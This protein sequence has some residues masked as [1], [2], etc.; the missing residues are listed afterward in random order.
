M[1]MDA[2]RFQHLAEAYGAD[3]RRWPAAEREAA[4]AFL[5]ADPAHERLLFEARQLDAALDGAPALR[6]SAGLRERVLAAAPVRARPAPARRGLSWAWLSGAGWA[7]AGVAGIVIGLASGHE[8]TRDL[9]A[10]AV[11]VQADSWTVDD[12]EILG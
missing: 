3:L 5:A 10:D 6:V 1:T 7:A 4:R 11:L 2:R 9:Q 12:M 8:V